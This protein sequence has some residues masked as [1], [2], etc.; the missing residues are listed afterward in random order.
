MIVV[1]GMIGLGKTSVSQKLGEALNTNVLFEKVDGN[2]ILPLFYKASE[3]ESQRCRYPFLL[4]L[5]FLNSR[6]HAI[7]DA[8]RD[9]DSIMDRSIYEDWYFAKKNQELG[10][11]SP[12]EMSIYESLLENMMEELDSLPKKSPDLMV[13]LKGSFETVLNRIQMRGRTF[14][15]GDELVDYY[16][17]L[18]EGYDDWVY[19][20][21]SAS[22][23]ITIDMDHTDIVHN[24]GDWQRVLKDIQAKLEAI[25]QPATIDFNRVLATK[26]A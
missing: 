21:Y 16:R 10:R 15:L 8:L 22:P 14:E 6:F 18:W 17:F 19:H 11:I 26:A 9:D 1:G 3:E 23:V 24:E 20:C 25:R 2:R 4:Q 12:L 5:E 13:Y 7:K